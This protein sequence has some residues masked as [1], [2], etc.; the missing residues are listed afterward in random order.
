MYSL[1]PRGITVHCLFGAQN[2]SDKFRELSP[3]DPTRTIHLNLGSGKYNR[4]IAIP[5]R[6]ISL[7]AR[8]RRSFSRT[9]KNGDRGAE[10]KKTTEVF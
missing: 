8:E 7:L 4:D 5:A 1:G 3:F 6:F 2:T 10:I 9:D